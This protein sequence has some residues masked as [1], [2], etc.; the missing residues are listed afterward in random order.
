MGNVLS[1]FF[2]TP[3]ATLTE[4]NCPDQTGR[5]FLVTGGYAGVGFELSQI[6]Y[7][8]NATVWIAGRS[9]SKARSAIESI[10][11]KSPKSKGHVH[12]LGLDL[13][14]LSTIK[15]AVNTFKAQQSRLDVLV[16]NAGVMFPPE[17]SKSAQG[18][19]LQIGTNCLGPY[20]LYKLLLPLPTQ[21]A[22]SS[23]TA[24]VRVIWAGSVAVHIA[25]PRPHG[26]VIGDDGEPTDQG[27]KPNYGQSK[28]GNVFLARECAKTTPQTGVVHAA[29][30]PG[31]LRSEL[32]RNWTGLDHWVADNFVLHS[33][34]H[35]AHT[36][37][38]AAIAP[39]LTL[40][41]SGAYVY[42]W[43]R[44]GELPAG[45]EASLKAKSEGGTGIAAKFGEWCN[46]QTGPFL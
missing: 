3:A 22:T 36:E 8:H 11:K 24:S 5:V 40:D 15:P 26:I 35:G 9:E 2:F 46:K 32:Q 37:L 31:N 7:A 16:N 29:F 21:T 17:G 10:Q 19:D 43:G 4:E 12:F 34:V 18:H 30:N 28:V 1:Q 42:P 27:V 44:F 39:E 38:W 6:L 14:D 25:S 23:P 45:I 33:A 41:K 13:S 20:L